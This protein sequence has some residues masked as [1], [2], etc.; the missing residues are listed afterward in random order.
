M[1]RTSA[2]ACS[3]GLL[4]SDAGRASFWAES[5]SERDG[6]IEFRFINGYTHGS[7]VLE[8]R[9]PHVWAIEYFDGPARFVL[10]PDD[11]G[12]TDLLLTHEGV[13]VRCGMKCMQAGST[14]SSPSR[15]GPLMA[16]ICVITTLDGRGIKVTLINSPASAVQGE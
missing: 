6:V 13:R 14:C 16:S 2:R 1:Q 9:P 8:R 11:A 5:A 12:G 15:P 10:R 7:K 4:D 3:L